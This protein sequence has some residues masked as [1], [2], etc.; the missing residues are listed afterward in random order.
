MS[1][2]KYAMK[3]IRILSLLGMRSL[4]T[5]NSHLTLSIRLNDYPH[6]LL[7]SYSTLLLHWKG[8]VIIF[9]NTNRRKMTDHITLIKKHQSH[10]HDKTMCKLLKYI[11][12]NRMKTGIH[13]C[14]IDLKIL[15]YQRNW[16]TGLICGRIVRMSPSYINMM[17]CFRKSSEYQ[18]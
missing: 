5:T 9:N 16:T 4:R 15:A 13:T 8:S 10:S 12:Y 17:L 18:I 2:M 14:R 1:S 6:A 7:Y 3:P 11:S